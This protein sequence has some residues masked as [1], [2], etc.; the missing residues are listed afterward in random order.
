MASDQSSTKAGAQTS[1][2]P[3]ARRYAAALFDL[4]RQRRVLD[5]IAGDL[6]KLCAALDAAPALAA[7]FAAPAAAAPARRAGLEALLARLELGALVQKFILT[8]AA[9]RR[10]AHVPA[11]ARAFHAL[12]AQSEGRRDV[13]VLAPA[14]LAPAQRRK[15]EALLRRAF[16]G[17][18]AALHIL[19]RRDPDLL[20]G[21]IVRAAGQEIDASLAGKLRAISQRLAA[22]SPPGQQRTPDP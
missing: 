21:L 6:E 8:L 14:P 10:L 5:D 17:K 20:G 11:I 19:Y 12:R 2:D 16:G 15:L 7:F 9:N 13:E 4:A 1:F 3:V 18:D 22:S